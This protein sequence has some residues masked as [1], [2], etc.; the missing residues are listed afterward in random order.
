MSRLRTQGVNLGSDAALEAAC[1][2]LVKSTLLGCLVG[3]GSELIVAFLGFLRVTSFNSGKGIFPK[4]FQGR[5]QDTI[6][7]R[8]GLGLSN[9][10]E[11]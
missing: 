3:C 5:F 10:F 9:A 8:A 1:G 2:I 6:T 11:C 4:R 7:V